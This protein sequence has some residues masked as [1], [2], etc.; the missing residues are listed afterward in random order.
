[1]TQVSYGIESFPR[2]KVWP[3]IYFCTKNKNNK[4]KYKW[5]TFHSLLKTKLSYGFKTFPRYKIGSVNYF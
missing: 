3:I 1:M 4:F 5:A 2:Y